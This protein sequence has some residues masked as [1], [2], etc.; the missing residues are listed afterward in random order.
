[1]PHE[2]IMPALGMAQSTG[3]ITAWHKEPGDAV[4][5]ADILFEVETDKSTVE[6]EAGGDGYLAEVRFDAGAEVPVGDVIAVIS[7][8]AGAHESAPAADSGKAAP[9]AAETEE[10]AGEAVPDGQSV[11]M[12]A[13]GMAQDSGL[14]TAWHKAPGDAVSAS[15][16]LF[17]VETDKS[18]V[19]VEAGHDGYVAALLAEAGEE[20]PVGATIAVISADKPEAPVQRSVKGAPKA[21]PAQAKDAPAKAAP[22]KSAKSTEDAKAPKAAPAAPQAEG[23]RVLASPKARRLA[24]EQGLDLARLVAE[25]IPQPYH[26]ADLETLKAL[27]APAAAAASAATGGAE[28]TA[29]ADR[30]GFAAFRDFLAAEAEVP[31]S[32][33]WAAFAA[34]ALRAAAPA[35]TLT[36]RVEDPLRGIAAD[37]ADPDRAPLSRAAPAEGAEPDLLLRDLTASRITG[38][39][40]GGAGRPVL[41]LAADGDAYVLTLGFDPGTL[42]PEA[43]MQTIE[44]MAARLEEPLRHLL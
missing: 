4:A 16:I 44:G 40:L 9:E 36:V 12:P 38:L 13:L 35:E 18:T 34:A 37:Y 20:A 25:G 30:A 14:I 2:V 10:D 11:I 17:E 24:A 43:A 27:P 26:V 39:R 3:L 42:S 29:R 1:M 31:D 6:V 15:D 21:A 7:D 23:G 22:E 41:S 5:A 32:A 28:I 19:E 33:V 8:E